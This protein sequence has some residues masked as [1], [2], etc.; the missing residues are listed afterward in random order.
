MRADE[1]VPRRWNSLIARL[2]GARK[3]ERLSFIEP[4]HPTL[5]EHAPVGSDWLYEIKVDGYRA[6]V[7]VR[8]SKATVYSRRGLNWTEQFGSIA[9]AAKHIKA[10]QLIMDGEVVVFGANGVPDFQALR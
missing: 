9:A 10:R 8:D 6:Q 1:P 2:P 5:G 3:A 4:C 7:H